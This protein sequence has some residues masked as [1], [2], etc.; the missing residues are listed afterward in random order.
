MGATSVKNGTEVIKL[1]PFGEHELD[2][3]SRAL[4]FLPLFQLYVDRYEADEYEPWDMCETVVEAC[5]ELIEGLISGVPPARR[6][7][8]MA[9]FVSEAHELT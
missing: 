2:Y 8:T 9:E 4:S 5:L 1:M 6:Y 3:V 7:E